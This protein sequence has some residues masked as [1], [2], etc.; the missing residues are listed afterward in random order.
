MKKVIFFL[1]MLFTFYWSGMYH[2]L[3]LLALCLAEFLLFLILYILPRVLRRHLS[4]AF[5][6]RKGTALA[7]AE[8]VCRVTVQNKGKLPVSRI[9]LRLR[10]WYEQDSKGVEKKLYGGAS[11]GESDLEFALCPTY[12]GLLRVRIDR[13][14]V[15]DYLS[16]FSSA[17]KIKEDMNIAIFPGEQALRITFAKFG[18]EQSDMPEEQTVSR[19]GDSYNEI[20]QIREYRM[21]DPG[22]H[23]HRNLSAR[24]DQLWVKEYERDTDLQA[25][26]L[27]DLTGLLD[28]STPSKSAF[29][30]LLSALV[31]GL[32]KEMTM[33]RL[34]WDAAD[35][36]S[37]VHAN[38]A[39]KEQCRELLLSLY[40][41][42]FSQ[43][44][45]PTEASDRAEAFGESVF[46]LT[47]ELSLFAGDTLLHRFSAETLE[48]EIQEKV[49]VI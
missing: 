10:V 26:I 44:A 38:V 48:Q 32:L 22:R 42:E 41:A 40:Q 24:T 33:V 5:P 28:A 49:F 2:S 6:K 34:H 14:R 12:C 3:P 46:K 39:N 18:W 8:T 1:L 35:G 9:G 25:D 13:L 4:V 19:P 36:E 29:Y 47:A 16:L 27:L 31:L 17:K 43:D 20:R 7:N 37:S 21:G 23:I 15:Y 30:Q 11:C 45:E